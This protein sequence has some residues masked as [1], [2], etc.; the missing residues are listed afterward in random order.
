[1]IEEL[2]ELKDYHKITWDEKDHQLKRIINRSKD[3][4]SNDIAGISLDFE[5]D[6]SNKQLL[7][8]CCR[9]IYNN[10]FEYFKVNFRS[11]LLRL[12][13]KSAVRKNDTSE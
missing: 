6:T 4:L 13:L 5:A 11:E 1:M 2:E 3:Y 9:Y 12:Q 8:D 7:L 10:A